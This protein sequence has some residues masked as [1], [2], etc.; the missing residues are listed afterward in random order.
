[1]LCLW[2]ALLVCTRE[3]LFNPVPVLLILCVLLLT[4]SLPFL[5]LSPFREFPSS[6]LTRI[7]QFSWNTLGDRSA[8][9]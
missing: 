3:G 2:N 9:F 5:S 8:R 6:V 1:M 4:A 7:P